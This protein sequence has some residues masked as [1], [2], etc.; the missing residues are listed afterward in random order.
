MS[1]KELRKG[2]FISVVLIPFSYACAQCLKWWESLHVVSEYIYFHRLSRDKT[3][4]LPY[5]T[6]L[7]VMS[8]QFQLSSAASI[9]SSFP[10][11][12]LQS[13][14]FIYFVTKKKSSALAFLGFMFVGRVQSHIYSLGEVPRAPCVET[15]E[16]LPVWLCYLRHRTMN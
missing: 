15:W 6:F 3:C 5:S 7:S 12:K 10:M 13:V 16:P 11:V 14:L 1:M 4:K 2:L 9:S 8:F